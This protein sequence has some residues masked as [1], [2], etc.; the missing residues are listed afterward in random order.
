MKHLRDDY[1]AIQAYP[2]KRQHFVRINGETVKAGDEHLGLHMDPI[3]P[4][5]EPVF[6]L[7]A[8]DKTAPYVVRTWA[9]AAERAG[10]DKDLCERVREF[11][12]EMELYAETHYAGGKT[13]DTPKNLLQ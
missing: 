5:D 9:D 2:T 6:L 1:N 13:P 11:A 3:I 8:K 7:R 10:A 12:H 4:D